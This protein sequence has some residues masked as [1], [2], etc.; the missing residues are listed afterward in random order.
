[1][2]ILYYFLLLTY[3][4]SD[5]EVYPCAFLIHKLKYVSERMISVLVGI[6][7]RKEGSIEFG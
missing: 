3:I 7:D 5:I 2:G 1:M 4:Q 6:F